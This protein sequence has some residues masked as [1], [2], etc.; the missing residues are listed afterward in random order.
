MLRKVVSTTQITKR[1]W[2]LHLD[3]GH[4]AYV[5]TQIP[6]QKTHICPICH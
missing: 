1:R 2:C 3:C 6:V 5:E 4:E